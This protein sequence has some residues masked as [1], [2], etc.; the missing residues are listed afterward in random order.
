[1][2]RPPLFHHPIRIILALV[3]LCASAAGARAQFTTAAPPQRQM[4]SVIGFSSGDAAGRLRQLGLTVSTRDVPSAQPQGTVISQRPEAGTVIRQG[5][6][7]TLDISTGQA[8]GE[9]QQPSGQTDGQQRLRTVPD[10]TGL[11]RTGVL[12]ALLAAGLAP[13]PVDSA[14]VE[15]ARG[16]RVVAQD[17]K[18]GAQVARGTRVSVT[19]ARHATPPVQPQPQPQPQPEPRQPRPE[20]VTVPNLSTL[21]EAQARTA[22]GRARLLLGAADS[23]ESGFTAPGTVFA[24]RPAAGEAVPPGTFVTVTLTRSTRVTMPSLVGRPVA[25]ARRVL[26]DA[27]LRAGGV[28]ERDARGAAGRVLTQSIPAGTRVRPGTAVDL[29]VSRVPVAR[30]D[31]PAVATQPPAP[32]QRDTPARAQQDTPVAAQPVQPVTDS[33]VAQPADTAVVTP[34]VVGQQPVVPA[35]VPAARDRAPVRVE[36]PAPGLDGGIPREVLWGLVALLVLIAAGVLYRFTRRGAEPEAPP[37]ATTAVV[38]PPAAGAVRMRVGAGEW[39]SASSAEGPV[40]GA[41]LRLNVRIADPV[42]AAEPAGGA[43]A[44]GR[45]VVRMVDDGAPSVWTDGSALA[46]AGAAVQVRVRDG[47]PDLTTDGETPVIPSRRA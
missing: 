37:A 29:A 22:L 30:P 34:P 13:G 10:L 33:A 26:A 47:A 4:P 6:T 40:Q 32:A 27:G 12:V 45:A 42:P 5:Q 36:L 21:T 11:N 31:S 39:Q 7:A 35:Q 28:T 43:L 14:T 25:E 18:A 19:L 2:R 8:P 17:P 3:L 9:T 24:Q 44:A 1:M 15:G 16:G 23:S 38:P 41:K 46:H 20:T